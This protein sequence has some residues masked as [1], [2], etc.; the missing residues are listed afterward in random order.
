ME[1]TWENTKKNKHA[2]FFCHS[3]NFL[4][5]H[6]LPYFDNNFDFCSRPLVQTTQIIYEDFPWLRQFNQSNVLIIGGGPS[7]IDYSYDFLKYDLI[8]S[9]ANFFKNPKIKNHVHFA[10]MCR[11]YNELTPLESL[12]TIICFERIGPGIPEFYKNHHNRCT[13]A[14][15]RYASWLGLGTRLIVMATLWGAKKISVIGIDGYPPRIRQNQ[16]AF[17]KNVPVPHFYS[18]N[19]YKRL[20]LEFWF[21]LKYEIGINVKYINLGYK[22]PYNI[23]SLYLDNHGNWLGPLA[24]K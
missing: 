22:H 23:S 10:T 9:C 3:Q 7:A 2:S 5:K 1:T 14:V 19:L 11:K 24:D 21:Y 15:T 4:L 16:H 8:C 17:E 20:Y 18:Y 12:S 6:G 13:L